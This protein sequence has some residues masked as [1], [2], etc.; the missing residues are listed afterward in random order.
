VP[1]R[2][3]GAIILAAQNE[4]ISADCGTY[5]ARINSTRSYLKSD[6]TDVAQ[7][8]WSGVRPSFFRPAK[9]ETCRYLEER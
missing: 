1:G 6:A 2:F 3:M 8:V 7:R 4:R 9:F 5:Q